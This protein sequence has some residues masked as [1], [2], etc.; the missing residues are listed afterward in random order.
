MSRSMTRSLPRFFVPTLVIMAL[1][2]LI[3]AA[4]AVYARHRTSDSPRVHVV[5]DMDHQPKFR[6][7]TTNPVFADGRA[8]RRPVQGTVARGD[9]VVDPAFAKGR[10]DGKWIA[11]I[12]VPVDM[13]LMVRGRERFDVFCATCHGWSGRGNGPT[14][15]VATKAALNVSDL[16]TKLVREREAGHLFNTITNG[17]GNMASYAAQIPAGDRWAIVAYIRALQRSQNAKIEDVPEELRD[18]LR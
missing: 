14:A 6:P 18:Q 9:L 2:G 8:M 5:H 7:Q 4:F 1:A 3:P 12:P 17:L 15:E 10:V 16:H 13:K 11:R